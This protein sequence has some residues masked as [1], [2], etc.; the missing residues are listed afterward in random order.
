VNASVETLR[1]TI[2]P[3]SDQLNADDLLTG[4]MTVT[5]TEVRRGDKDQPVAIGIVGHQPYKPCKSMRRVLISAWGDDGRAWAG[6]KMTLYC[7]PNV[8]FGGVKVGGIRISHLSHIDNDM[9]MSLTATRGKKA[10]YLVKVLSVAMYP[11]EQFETNFPKWEK[12]IKENRI[13]AD[14]TIARAEQT[15]RLTDQ[16]KQRLRDCSTYM[17]AA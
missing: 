13:T 10:P 3:K 12:A 15:G 1:D 14:Q 5:I 2:V 16:Q 4:P 11:A 6:R 7:D 9:Q 17:P 8:M